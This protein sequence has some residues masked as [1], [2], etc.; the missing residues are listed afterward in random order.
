MIRLPGPE[1][2]SVWGPAPLVLGVGFGVSPPV[3]WGKAGP[4]L[5]SLGAGDLVTPRSLSSSWVAAGA[6]AGVGSN[7]THPIRGKKTSTQS[8]ASVSLTKKLLRSGSRP[9]GANPVDTRL[10]MPS[11]RSI[12]A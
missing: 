6:A 3:D 7:V 10:G 8:C 4:E 5:F 11:I 1:P 12:R 2:P 9:P